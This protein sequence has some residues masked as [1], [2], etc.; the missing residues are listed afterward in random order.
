M[1]AKKGVNC[2][3]LNQ[4]PS[5]RPPTAEQLE[6]RAFLR[7]DIGKIELYGTLTAEQKQEIHD[8]VNS[9][10]RRNWISWTQV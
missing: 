3:F 10:E 1:G 2:S 9:K 5:L 8:R 4:L 6:K 7:E